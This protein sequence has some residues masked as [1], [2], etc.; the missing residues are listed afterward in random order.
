MSTILATLPPPPPLQSIQTRRLLAP[1]LSARA[2]VLPALP[3]AV[4][5]PLPLFMAPRISTDSARPPSYAEPPSYFATLGLAPG[6]PGS[7]RPARYASIVLSGTDRLR[8]V[9]FPDEDISAVVDVVD[10]ALETK[11]G[12]QA[13]ICPR[14]R[15]FEWKLK[16]RPCEFE[17]RFIVLDRS[18]LLLRRPAS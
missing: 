8:L 9:G 7:S 10:L 12:V 18:C 11:W 13:R 5:N 15:V 3:S 2:P 1:P 14:S 4:T 17:P 16:G 6:A